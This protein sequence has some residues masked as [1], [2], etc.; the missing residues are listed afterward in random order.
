MIKKFISSTTFALVAIAMSAAPISRQQAMS[1]AQASLAKQ[2]I[3]INVASMQ[4][5]P[6]KAQGTHATATPAY[7][8]FNSSNSFVI[9]AGDD[10]MP[11]VLGYSDNGTIDPNDMPE[12]LKELLECYAVQAAH[13]TGDDGAP[14]PNG[15]ISRA[16][17]APLLTS[18]WNQSAPF[19]NLCPVYTGTTRA[20][21]GCVA[22]AMAQVMYYHKWP[23]SI[24]QTIPAYTTKTKGIYM[25]ALS[26]SGFPSMSAMKDYYFWNDDDASATAVAKLML[27]CG[28]SLE[29]NYNNSSGAATANIGSALYK[30][31]RYGPTARY[32]S[33]ENYTAEEW[34]TI[35]YSELA[36]KRPV[37]YRGSAYSGG[38]HSFICDGIDANGLFHINWGWSGKS[39]GYFLLT[40]LNPD[41][42][43]A[44]SSVSDDGYIV[45]SSMIIG[46]TPENKTISSLEQTPMYCT[47]MTPTSASVIRSSSSVSFP[48]VTLHFGVYSQI[49]T[50]ADLDYGLGLYSPDGARLATLYSSWFGSL[51][52]NYGLTD[53]YNISIP[54]SIPSG[55]FYIKPICRYH[56]NGDWMPCSGANINY[57]KASITSTKLTITA[58][59]L[60][61]TPSYKV[62][63]V[64]YNGKMESGRTVEMVANLTNTGTTTYRDLYLLVDG[65][66]TT[67]AQCPI[68]P[69]KTGNISMHFNAGEARSHTLK[70][71]Y[72]E[73]GNQTLWQ[74]SISIPQAAENYLT[75]NSLSVKNVK[76][77]TSSINDDKLAF[78]IK[79]V[80]SGETNYNDLIIAR[81]YRRAGSSSGSSVMDVV[82]NLSLSKG[83]ST[84]LSFEFPDLV[85]NE[86]YFVNLYYYSY[87]ELTRTNLTGWYTILGGSNKKGDVDGNGTV[88]IND[89]N[90]LINILLGKDTASKYSGRADVD[91][92]GTID[93]T[94]ANLLINILLGK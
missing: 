81:I 10:R 23:T 35:I 33:R 79:V 37:V 74:S 62:N 25:P 84:T 77:G 59:G 21:T 72:D 71:C 78:T 44:G 31:F 75:F 58:V 19:N 16:P 39:D 70:L 86:D 60:Y 48:S 26:A 89:T 27:Y 90:I 7:Y 3:D 57:W 42:Q 13:L 36:A 24:S 55:T 49:A 22:T 56:N 41:D 64:T 2:G 67:L 92:N 4:A 6:L 61:G 20:V 43:G 9:A 85:K 17:I 63:N 93:I 73:N 80:N 83:Q 47:D 51:P 14:V 8:V 12:G 65:K 5:M 94:D 69:G 29:M 76:S 87:G 11:E 45:G 1:R 53:D 66:C 18:K 54:A 91:G 30:Y 88:D 68:E 32:L 15:S 46:I 40:N 82:K 52:P 38:G 50:T 34:A 28:Q